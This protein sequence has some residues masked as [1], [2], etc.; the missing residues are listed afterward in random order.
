MEQP[1]PDRRVKHGMHGHPLYKTWDGMIGR[2]TRPGDASYAIYGGRGI[3]VCERWR[4]PRLFI[5]DILRDLGPRPDGC[6]LDRVDNDGDYKPGN[7]RW[8]TAAEQRGNQRPTPPSVSVK[9]AEL[10]KSRE[11]RTEVCEQCG[12]EYRT[13]ALAGSEALRFCSKKCKAKHRRASGVD[14]V[15]RA[16]HIC[17]AGFSCNRYEPTSHCSRPCAATC[18]HRGGCPRN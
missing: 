7:V 4:D 5:A 15:T 2:T 12:G 17:G 1:N 13:R 18:G 14:D 8:A 16:C 6:T 10:W 3:S 9:V 11:Y